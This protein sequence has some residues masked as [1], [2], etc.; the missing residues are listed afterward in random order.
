MRWSRPEVRLGWFLGLTT[1]AGFV[2]LLF[3]GEIT[4]ISLFVLPPTFAALTLGGGSA[5][6]VAAC[7]VGW[8][9]ILSLLTESFSGP[10][11]GSG[12]GTVVVV[13][14]VSVLAARRR[15]LGEAALRRIS[16]IAEAAQATIAR[17]IP[18]QLGGF[19]FATVYRSAAEEAQVGGDAYAAV[20]RPGG[21]RLLVADVRGK[22]LPAVGLAAEVLASFREFAPGP[23]ELVD[24]ARHL[25]NAIRP[26]LSAEDF[27]TAMLVDITADGVGLVSCGHPWPLLRHGGSVGEIVID[28]PSLPLGLG[29]R[30]TLQQHPFVP[31]DQLYV[32][33]DGLI[34][35]RDRAGVFF[36][37]IPVVAGLPATASPR[38][39]LDTL[40]RHLDEHAEG[41]LGDDLAIVLIEHTAG[42]AASADPAASSRPAADPEPAADLQPA[43]NRDR[44]AARPPITQPDA[45]RRTRRSTRVTRAHRATA[46][47]HAFPPGTRP[48]G[49]LPAG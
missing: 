40:L 38:D 14:A 12:L 24:V 45:S 28:R 48:V 41:R 44:P 49:R 29:V 35:A 8:A 10:G 23:V 1:L 21:A 6:L 3:A 15:Q 19:S 22:G 33:T 42:P 46:G 26:M 18:A 43:G 2:S 32:F 31:G 47:R 27:V 9:L 16:L 37:P 5:A 7:S 11:H 4:L 13:A 30:P 34:E 17:P 39:A 36:D 20:A 25:E